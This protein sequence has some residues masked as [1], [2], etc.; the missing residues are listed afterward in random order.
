VGDRFTTN[1]S[2]SNVGAAAIGAG[3]KATGSVTL[4]QDGAVQQ[5]AYLEQLAAARKALVDDEARL[6]ELGDGLAEALGQFLKIA[7]T[8]QVD[9]LS[10]KDANAKMKETLDG[11]WARDVA[12]KAKGKVIPA[13]LEFAKTLLTSPITVEVA[14]AWFGL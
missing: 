11:L 3:A 13:T 2:N 12:T 7:R 8:I 10:I 4:P 5:A 6:D 9:Q 14:K 1:I